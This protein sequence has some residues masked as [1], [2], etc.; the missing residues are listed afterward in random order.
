SFHVKLPASMWQHSIHN[1]FHAS[2]LHI[3]H[4][5]DDPLFPGQLNKQVVEPEQHLHEWMADKILSHT[6]TKS[7]LLFEVL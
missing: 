7:N 2:L 4:P 1:V 3:H 5:N 6:G